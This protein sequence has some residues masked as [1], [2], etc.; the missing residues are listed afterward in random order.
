MMEAQIQVLRLGEHARQAEFLRQGLPQGA[1]E[2][3]AQRR[4]STQPDQRLGQGPGMSG[5]HQETGLLMGDQLQDPPHSRGRHR[6]AQRGRLQNGVGQGL[7]PGRQNENVEQRHPGQGVRALSNKKHGSR[8][9][10]TF[11]AALKPS[12]FRPPAH[13]HEPGVRKAV[14]HEGSGLDQGVK[15]LDPI[16]AGHGSDPEVMGTG[17]DLVHD[18]LRIFPERGNLDIKIDAV[19]DDVPLV[20]RNQAKAA[21]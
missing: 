11:G 1:A 6:L 8:H 12:A 5:I 10:E 9:T 7:M 21:A 18:L 13:D 20:V 17:R 16:Q 15:P 19:F 14:E 3:P 2:P 4:V